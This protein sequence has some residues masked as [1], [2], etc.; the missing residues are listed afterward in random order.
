[1]NGDFRQF[2]HSTVQSSYRRAVESL[3]KLC[4]TG[5]EPGNRA[6][7]AWTFGAHECDFS[8]EG[9]MWN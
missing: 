3:W 9:W 6:H 5:W 4:Q 2:F 7:I 8:H 1:M